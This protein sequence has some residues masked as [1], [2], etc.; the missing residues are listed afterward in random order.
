M[1]DEEQFLI[2][3]MSSARMAFE[4]IASEIRALQLKKNVT[5]HQFDECRQAIIDYMQGNGLVETERLKLG[6]SESVDIVD[7]NAVPDEF[8]RIK[9]EPNKAAIRAMK[10]VGNWYTMKENVTLIVKES[11]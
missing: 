8:M 3:K 11:K 5:E 7:E 10:P 9:K 2:D 4:A 6:K 1:E